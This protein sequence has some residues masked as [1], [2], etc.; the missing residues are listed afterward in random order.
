[1]KIIIG[2]ICT[3]LGLAFL[4]AGI[5]ALLF[6]GVFYIVFWI[7]NCFKNE[8]LPLDRSEDFET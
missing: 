3:Y 4:F 6:A 7:A 1:M 5:G 2:L 8:N